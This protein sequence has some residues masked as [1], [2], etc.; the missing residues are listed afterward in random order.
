M[1]KVLLISDK[2]VKIFTNLDGNIDPDFITPQINAAQDIELERILGTALLVKI[3]NEI[4]ADTLAG[5]YEYLV[6]EYIKPCLS[7]YTVAY[8]IPFHAYNVDKKGLFK[9]Q[10][11]T[12][13]TPDKS[14][15]DYLR[16]IAES[17]G[18][19][20]GDRMK[21]YICA[22]NSDYP[23]YSELENGGRWSDKGWESF[24]GINL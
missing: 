9:H 22:N 10:S 8:L 17:K 23:E 7:W 24:G 3:Q 13:V 6:D 21:K 4:D 1:A 20:Y 18:Q 11:E 5:V 2:D 19:F 16:S 12:S 15:I 14:E